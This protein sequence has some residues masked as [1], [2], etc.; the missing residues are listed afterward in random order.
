[1]ASATDDRGGNP[2]RSDSRAI[3]TLAYKFALSPGAHQS[4][5]LDRWCSAS[6]YVWNWALAEY[7]S[8]LDEVRASEPDADGKRATGSV[9]DVLEHRM[10]ERGLEINRRGSGPAKTIALKSIIYKLWT[11]HRDIEAPPW[12]REGVHSHVGSYA[13]QRLCDAASRWWAAKGKRAPWVTASERRAGQRRYR[14]PGAKG[15]QGRTVGA[16][17]YKRAGDNPSF[18]IQ[19]PKITCWGGRSVTVPMLGRVL[20]DDATSGAHGS[21]GWESPMRRIPEGA[22]AKV[23]TV[24]KVARTRWEVSIVVQEPWETPAPAP[25]LPSCGIDLGI[26][27]E[28]TIAW[29]DGRIERIEPPRP[30]ASLGVGLVMVQRRLSRS[31][32]WLRCVDCG[33]KTP[34]G[35]RDKRTRVCRAEVER[36]GETV[37]CGGRVRRWRSGRG[38]KLL[39]RIAAKHHHIERVRADHLHRLTH[40]LV[41]EASVICTEPHNVTGLVSAG[42]ARRVEKL[43]RRGLV[44]KD[45]RRAMLDIGWGEFRRQLGYKAPWKGREYLT[46]LQGTRTDQ[47]CHRCARENKMPDGT[48]EYRCEGCGWTGTRQENTA[49]LCLG[50]VTPGHE[51]AAE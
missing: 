36:D 31:E 20:V 27:A 50:Y 51:E 46:M 30:M 34:L 8:A 4:R 48:S 41:G 3:R 32:H 43:Y 7:E 23:I 33:H 16:P 12:V 2:D 29:S 6:R 17:R 11:H 35:K 49:L 14:G 10:R 18:T 28:C 38:M 19:A 9:R 24:R 25:H 37:D 5:E 1:M 42:V 22:V 13:C 40:R 26:N 44:R 21:G 45:I 15:S 39:A 47:A